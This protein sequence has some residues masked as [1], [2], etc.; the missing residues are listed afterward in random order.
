MQTTRVIKCVDGNYE[1]E[2][3]LPGRVDW[4]V[5][6]YESGGASYYGLRMGRYYTKFHIVAQLRAFM[7]ALT[8]KIFGRCL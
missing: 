6:E 3:R 7:L 4:Y 2:F 5:L 1:V 8:I